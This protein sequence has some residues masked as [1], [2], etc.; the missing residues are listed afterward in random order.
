MTEETKERKELNDAGCST[1]TERLN[2]LQSLCDNPSHI[3]EGLTICTKWPD[4]VMIV[5]PGDLRKMIDELM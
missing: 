5:N 3:R 2:Y 4:G 1:D